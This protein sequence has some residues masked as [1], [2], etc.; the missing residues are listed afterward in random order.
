[1]KPVCFGSIVSVNAASRTCRACE[2]APGCVSAAGALLDQ[3]PV[4]D[5]TQRARLDW[6]VACKAL[7]GTPARAVKGEGAP[8]VTASTR[9]VKRID[10]STAETALVAALPPRV[11][12]PVRQ[13]LQRG[14]FDF[15]RRELAAGRNP[16]AKGWMR[17]TCQALLDGRP[18]RAE[19]LLAFQQQ[20][21]LSEPSARV[22]A[23][24]AL[25]V[26]AAGQLA[27]EAGGRIRVTANPRA[28]LS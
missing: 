17:V 4:T 19:L 5:H 10:L 23:S 13:L 27:H 22:Q 16:A 7:A 24:I 2:H 18:T 21:G 26:F 25:A 3:L 15:A 14:W 11:A 8:T 28:S 12:S 6:A 9:G 20:L 1:L